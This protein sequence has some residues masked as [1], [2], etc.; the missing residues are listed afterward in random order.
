MTKKFMH[1]II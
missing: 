1:L